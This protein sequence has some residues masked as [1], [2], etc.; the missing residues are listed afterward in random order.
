MVEG[1]LETVLALWRFFCDLCN[2]SVIVVG[3]LW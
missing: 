3:R 2:G 1:E